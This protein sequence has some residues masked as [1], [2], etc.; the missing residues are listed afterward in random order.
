MTALP[1]GA[2]GMLGQEAPLGVAC[3]VYGRCSTR[4]VEPDSRAWPAW[5][6]AS[7]DFNKREVDGL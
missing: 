4:S 6:D 7:V 2:A 3:D 5:R 1:T